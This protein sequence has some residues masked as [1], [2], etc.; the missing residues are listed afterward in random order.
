[1]YYE[2]KEVADI[3]KPELKE[4]IQR[5]SVKRIDPSESISRSMHTHFNTVLD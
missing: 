3:I 1:M 5:R 4:S 2:E